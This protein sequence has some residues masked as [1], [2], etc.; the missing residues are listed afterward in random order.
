MAKNRVKKL[1]MTPTQQSGALRAIL[2]KIRMQPSAEILFRDV[3]DTLPIPLDYIKI[4]YDGV[5]YESARGIDAATVP[6]DSIFV[7]PFPHGGGALSVGH[8]EMVSMDQGLSKWLED[9]ATVLSLIR[10]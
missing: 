9:V 1:K 4:E 5:S 7:F 6:V 3:V 2:E 10:K 8:G